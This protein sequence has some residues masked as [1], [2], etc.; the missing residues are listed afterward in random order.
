MMLARFDNPRM[1]QA[2]SDYLRSHDLQ[3][4]LEPAGEGFELWV[5][6]EAQL[7]TVRRELA[8]FRAEPGHPRYFHASWQ[9][10]P[11]AQDVD[12]LSR[13]YGGAGDLAPGTLLRSRG[14]VTLI[15]LLACVA[16]GFVTGFGER[17]SVVRA[18]LFPSAPGDPLWRALSPVLL[19]FGVVHLVFN[20]LWWWMLGGIIERYQSSFQ[21]AMLTVGIGLLSNAAQFY[22]A[23]PEFGG[24]SGVVYGLVG[25][26]WLYGQVNPRAGYQLQPAIVNFSLVWM[27]LGFTGWFGPVANTAHFAGLAAGCVI[28]VVFGL[29]RRHAYYR[30]D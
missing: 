12:R 18:M 17:E 4:R 9:A 29:Y 10:P 25:Y 6:D 13:R 11:P 22:V 3:H 20:L 16:V 19:H 21:L 2:F 26:L 27:A 15:V 14:P 1:A 24:L 8:R 28:G 30:D 23:G 7:D 5:D